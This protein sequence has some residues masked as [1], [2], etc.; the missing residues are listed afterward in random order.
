MEHDGW[1][2]GLAV[3]KDGKRILSG[4]KDRVLKAWDVE[5]HQPIAKWGGHHGFISCIAT[6]PDD[7]LVASGDYKGRIVIKEMKEGGRIKHAI[8]TGWH[9][10][11]VHSICF[12]PDGTKLA[13][14][15][16]DKMI[17][18][19]DVENGNLI[20]L[21]P[22][23]GH[24]GWVTSVVWS[25]DGSQL[26]TAS[27]DRSIRFW[28]T[29]TGQAIG[30][31]LTGHTQA[32]SSISLSPDG[33]KLA[34]ASWD[35]TVRFWGTDSGDPIGE[36]LQHETGIEVV[37][38]SPSGEFVACG[39]QSGKVSIWR[40]PWWDDSKKVIAYAQLLGR[41]VSHSHCHFR[42]LNRCW[43]CVL[44]KCF[45]SALLTDVVCSSRL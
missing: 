36:P 27:N 44:L 28:D 45:L 33:T 16:V 40:V 2:K 6:S 43:T 3:T 24:S 37:T 5:T 8:E 41:A 19:F 34:G 39:E 9:I 35:T 32:F 30:D 11:M 25:L 14:G 20:Q 1:V 18:V 23:Q 38:F 31:P 42:H 29:E 12:S 13:S 21:G 26:F 17:R 22:I 10:M 4:G 15:H 7:Q